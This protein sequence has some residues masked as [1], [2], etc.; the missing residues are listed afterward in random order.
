V[1]LMGGMASTAAARPAAHLP[2]GLDGFVDQVLADNPEVQAAEAAV[3]AAQARQRGAGLP[4]Y[5][6]ELEFESEIVKG[7]NASEQQYMGGFSQTVDWHNKRGALERAAAAELGAVQGELLAVRLN[8]TAELINALVDSQAALQISTLARQRRDILKRFSNLARRLH[9]AGDIPLVE[10]ELARLSLA[11]SGMELASSEAERISAG[12]AFYTVTGMAIGRAPKLP[13]A[14]PSSLPGG[15]AVETLAEIHPAVRAAHL[16]SQ[17]AMRQINA[18]DRSRKVDPT[19]GLL[20]GTDDGE[21]KLVLG[22]SIPLQ[23]RNNGRFNVDVAQSEAIQAEQQALQVYRAGV[24]RLRA[25]RER[26]TVISLAWKEWSARGRRSLDQ[27]LALLERLWRAGEMKTTD[28]LVQIQQTL[29]TRIAG[30]QLRADL[31]RAYVEWQSA[32]GTLFNWIRGD[33]R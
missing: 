15:G 1:L 18:A 2:A 17:A 12:Q 28:Y 33:V 22:F 19:F 32:A 31:W 25:A 30:A 4:L 5:N 14:P 7:R 11:E 8:K 9:S 27:R 10:L 21:G 24:A 29:D 16:R 23:V 13:E 6:P 26:W 20:G 3:S